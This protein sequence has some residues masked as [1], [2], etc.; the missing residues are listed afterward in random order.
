MRKTIKNILIGI[1]STLVI[2]LSNSSMAAGVAIQG[3]DNFKLLK[4]EVVEA[5]LDKVWTIKFNAMLNKDKPQNYVQVK[6]SSGKDVSVDVNLGNDGKSIVVTPPLGNYRDNTE[7]TIYVKS[8][9]QNLNNKELKQGIKFNFKSSNKIKNT[10]TILPTVGSEENLKK[11]IENFNTRN[12]YIMYPPG[13]VIN[14]V[15]DKA[16]SSSQDNGTKGSAEDY[17]TT[18]IQVQGVDEGDI[19][20]SDGEYIYSLNITNKLVK[21][22]KAF[23]SDKI[24]VVSSLSFDK[25]FTPQDIYI[26]GN[27][28][29]AIGTYYE[30]L[31]PSID[32][33]VSEN[34]STEKKIFPPY[35]RPTKNY[36]RA[37]IYD[38]SDKQKISQLRQIDIEGYYSSSRKIGSNLYLVSNKSIGYYYPLGNVKLNPTYRDTASSKDFTDI[39][40]KDIKYF[41]SSIEPSYM[42]IAGF[43]INNLEQKADINT[44]LGS[45]ENMYAS[46]DNLYM[47]ISKY[48]WNND[49]QNVTS[50]EIYKFALNNGKTDYKGKGE[51]PGT[52]LN[53]FAMDESGQYFRIATTK[54][55]TWATDQNQSQNNVYVLDSN[56]NISGKIEG[57]AKG[58]TIYSTRFL[59]DRLYMVTFRTVDPFYVIDLKDPSEP[60][61]LGALKIPGYSSYLHSYDENHI[62][63]FG[64]D[65]FEMSWKD[66]AGNIKGTNAYYAGMKMAMFDVTDV[67]NPK[68][69]FVEKIGDRGT[70]SKLLWDH[71]ALL[72][73]K[74]KN[75][76]SFPVTLREV[77]NNSSDPYGSIQ[78]GTFAFQGAYVYDIDLNKGFQLRGK[79]THWT[80]ADYDKADQY[81]I[82]G[83]KNIDRSIYIGQNIYT[84]SEGMIK[85]N[86]LNTLKEINSLLLNTNNKA[87]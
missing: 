72:F 13:A 69:M 2:A 42:T 39:D 62:I 68:E 70:D 24:N 61:I 59:G 67:N 30:D 35:Y 76:L 12:R 8:S 34:I 54:G 53:Q 6:D 57:I 85:V 75:L 52:I 55:S 77:K 20:K 63:G 73:S 60:K 65:T 87:D 27:K 4:N 28:L 25:N 31:A 44:Y 32:I 36:T 15:A 9:I 80:K 19:V 78:Y 14:G 18:N 79:I 22:V 49:N 26:D 40:F 5:P 7:Y 58:E 33:K 38:I 21:I 1:A 3:E 86:D 23:P 16:A 66:D 82:Y 41:P 37:I 48:D 43:D 81:E 51:V 45:S 46:K 74:D 17:S 11:L 50:T 64:K 56:L 71:K 10:D 29:V 47:A 84:I 83:D